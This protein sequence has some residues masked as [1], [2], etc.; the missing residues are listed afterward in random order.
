MKLDTLDRIARRQ[1]GVVARHQTE[2]S[3]SSWQRAT[4]NGTFVP[5]HRNVARLVGTADTSR[6]RIAAAVLAAGD[7]ALASHRSAALLHGI[8][9]VDPPPVDVIV[10]R[11]RMGDRTTYIR[12][13]DG[14]VV[15]RPSDLMRLKPH[16]QD[17]ISCTSILRT[18]LDLGAVAADDVHGAV[19]HALTNDLASIAA[20]ETVLQQHA[21]RG[22]AGVTALRSALDDWAIDAKPADSVLE[23]A[24]RRL[25]SAYG[26]PPIEFHPF[27]GG[28]EVD[29]RVV[30]TPIVIECDGWRYHGRARD[31]FE[32]DRDNDA[33]FAAHGWI[34]LRF[35]YRKITTRPSDV[36]AHIR[37]A[38]ERWV[39]IPAP[40]AA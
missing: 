15:H 6:Q 32:R 34:V 35:T 33:E 31:Q 22:R 21:R 8:P 11:T 9:T 29:F 20:I 37:R 7:G 24:M 12:G 27:V 38:V 40:D 14:V 25:V 19:G 16:R 18:L 23:P 3:S 39:D 4:T 5:I 30:G 2:L 26:L 28:R 36:A 10:P 17:N 1:H 13:L